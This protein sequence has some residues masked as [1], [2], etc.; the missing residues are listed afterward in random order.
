MR[1]PLNSLEGIWNKAAQLLK[2]EGSIVPAP[3]VGDDAKFVLSYSGH[4][5]Q[6][7]GS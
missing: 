7:G 6:F 3:G 2:T 1:I 5:P 4:K